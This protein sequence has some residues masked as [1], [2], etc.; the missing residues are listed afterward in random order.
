MNKQISEEFYN[1]FLKNKR[2]PGCTK[3]IEEVLGIPDFRGSEK[4]WGFIKKE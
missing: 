4:S 2:F 3:A 1:E